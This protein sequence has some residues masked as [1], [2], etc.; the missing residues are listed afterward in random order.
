MT[1]TAIEWDLTDGIATITLARPDR[2]NAF[3]GAL[4][5]DLLAA[6][7]A[8]D[9]D[10]AVR[11]VIIT[12]AG[13]AFSAGADLHK[14]ADTFASKDDSVVRPDGTI[15]YAGEAARDYGG[16]LTLRIF[17]MMKPVIG[18][19]NGAA[20][21]LG[22]TITLP[23]DIRLASD[24]ARF[25]FVFGR[26]GLVPEGA[27]S[28]FLPRIVGISQALAWCYSGRLVPADEALAGGLVS[29]V[30]PPDE[31]LPRARELAR[32]FVDNS[33][34]VSMA[35]I[36]QMLWRGLGMS[37][38]MEAHRI[39]SRGILARGRSADALEGV[40]SFLER[41]QPEFPDRVSRDMPDYYPWW[42]EPAYD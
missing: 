13:R 37:H 38:P 6:F 4:C 41:R 33:A 39:D 2:L 7:D 36:R 16:R 34:P 11:A 26:R 3:N 14:G 30:L 17:Q 25:G 12:G 35:L 9:A 8:A 18:A 42:E 5:R 32:D 10:D 24:T 15:N 1:Y 23:M 22:A 40:S 31:L 20:V 27:S 28:W 21:G 29:E 19:I